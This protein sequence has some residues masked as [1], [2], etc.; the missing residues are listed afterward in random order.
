MARSDTVV[1]D[2]QLGDVSIGDVSELRRQ[3]ATHASRQFLGKLGILSDIAVENIVP[4]VFAHS[5]GSVR[6]PTVADVLRNLE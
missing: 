6:Q 1:I 4:M 3:V 2:L 5:A